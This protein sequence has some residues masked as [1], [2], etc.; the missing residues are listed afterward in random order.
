[1]PKFFFHL[2]DGRHGISQDDMGLVFPDAEAAYLDA[3]QAA[4]DMAQEWLRHGR[5][6]RGY[7]F[8]VLNEAGDLIF[9]LPFAEVLDAHAGRRPVKQSKAVRV[10]KER[11]ERMVRLT[12]EVAQ[13]V[14]MAQQN[15]RRSQEL[16]GRL[17]PPTG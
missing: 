17:K 13:Q 15:L 4:R 11:G 10:V 2:R 5:N 14:K 3:F 6:V 1:M 16:L 8:E 9:E 7:A 12:T